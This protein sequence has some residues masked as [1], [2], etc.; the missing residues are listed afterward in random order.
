MSGG[1]GNLDTQ[2]NKLVDEINLVD[3]VACERSL[4]EE[5]AIAKKKEDVA[6]F[7]S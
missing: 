5:E 3:N 6:E 2:I 7:I 1:R 4:Q